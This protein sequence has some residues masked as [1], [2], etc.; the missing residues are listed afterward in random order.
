MPTAIPLQRSVLRLTGDDRVE[1]LQGLTT[2]DVALAGPDR[3][4][5]SVFLTPQGKFLHDF[6]IVATPDA[7]LIDLDGDGDLRADLL[8]RLKVYRLR[9]KVAIEDVSDQWA[10]V[11]LIDD[12]ALDTVGLPAEA[13]ATAEYE[14]GYA[15]TDPRTPSLG[16]RLMLPTGTAQGVVDG[17]AVAAGNADTYD[18]LRL[19]LGVP[20]GPRDLEREKSNVLEATLDQLNGISWT[21][22]CYMGQELTARV[23]Y[24]GLLKKRLVPVELDGPTPIAGS[25][26]TQNGRVVGGLRST[27]GEIGLALLRLDALKQPEPIVAGATKV[28]PRQAV[29]EKG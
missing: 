3:S 20:D 24:R 14:A 12:E 10:V 1:F 9:S 26:L 8:R 16:A 25:D 22:G 18:H 21:K 7:L 29:W 2:N 5:Y 6:L 4:I 19:S 11:A 17:L 23:H 27:A 13:G 28:T 15:L